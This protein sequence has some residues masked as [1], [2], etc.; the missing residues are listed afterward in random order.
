MAAMPGDTVIMR[1]D[2]R[3]PG[4][5]SGAED[6]AGGQMH[7]LVGAKAR[8]APD[9]V[10]GTATDGV[11]AAVVVKARGAF[12]FDLVQAAGGD[13]G[14]DIAHWVAPFASRRALRA[15]LLLALAIPFL[16]PRLAFGRSVVPG[17][18]PAVQGDGGVAVVH[19]EI[20]V[21]QV[22]G[23][24][25]AIDQLV[26]CDLD[27]VEA[28]MAGDR[29]EA[30]DVQLVSSNP[31]SLFLARVRSSVPGPPATKGS[32]SILAG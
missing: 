10:V 30:R 3:F 25:V 31:K 26:A 29:A 18:E 14:D 20:F 16:H 11:A 27:L 4:L 12:P 5:E 13:P 17:A 32:K 23:I 15:E 8:R 7:R 28:D 1:P 9:A 2:A 22:M 6:Q 24:G 21:M 19:L